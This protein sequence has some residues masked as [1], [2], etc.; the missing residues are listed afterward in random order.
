M[1]LLGL[2][3]IMLLY[4]IILYFINKNKAT[5]L[6]KDLMR[7]AQISINGADLKK[8]FVKSAVSEFISGNQTTLPLSRTVN[9]IVENKIDDINSYLRDYDKGLESEKSIMSDDGEYKLRL[10]FADGQEL[11]LDKNSLDIIL[12]KDYFYFDICHKGKPAIFCW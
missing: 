3:V 6:V 10:I 1:E 2:V 11:N 5:E 9:K 7:Y 12:K 4:I 8:E